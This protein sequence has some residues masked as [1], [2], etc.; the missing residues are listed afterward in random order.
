[1]PSMAA[2]AIDT[3][4]RTIPPPP[5]RA[6]R[7][8]ANLLIARAMIEA[9]HPADPMEAAEAARAVAAHFA[10]MDSPPAPPDPTWLTRKPCGCAPMPWPRGASSAQRCKT[11]AASSSRCA[12]GI[13]NSNGL[14]AVRQ[15][16]HR[17]RCVTTPNFRSRS[18][19]SPTP[20]PRYRCGR[21][22]ELH[23]TCP[24]A[25]DRPR[26]LTAYR[27]CV[28]CKDL[29]LAPIVTGLISV[30][31][32]RDPF[33][34]AQFRTRPDVPAARRCPAHPCRRR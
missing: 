2:A 4:V 18:P 20:S 8:A 16:R 34:S 1:M 22:G 6:R 24:R 31:L 15:C 28:R 17:S 30:A 33:R 5:T 13:T 26:A 3:L 25:T 27:P 11:T 29:P 14:A 19:A 12:A 32:L 7:R 10:A 9:F 23:G 21:H